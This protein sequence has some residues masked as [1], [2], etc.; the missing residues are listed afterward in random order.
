ARAAEEGTPVPSVTRPEAVDVALCYGWID[1][2]T[3]SSTMPDGWWAQ[4]FTPRRPRSTWSKVNRIHVERLIAAG[5]MRPAGQRQVDLAK[6]DG[7]WDPPYAPRSRAEV[8]PEF[9]A[10]LAESPAAAKAFEALGS[11]ARYSMIV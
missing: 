8:S 4:R 1:G 3:T 7:R 2:K 5:R 9:A 10:A 11:G 6:A